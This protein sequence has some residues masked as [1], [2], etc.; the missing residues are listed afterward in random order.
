MVY[1]RLGRCTICHTR[2]SPDNIYT[3]NNCNHTY[4]KNCI[5]R[6]I[7]GG[8]LAPAAELI[9]LWMI[10]NNFLLK[11]RVIVSQESDEDELN[12]GTSNEVVPTPAPV[13]VKINV[14]V[15]DLNNSKFTLQMKTNNT[16]LNLKNKVY[17]RKGH[18][19]GEQRLIYS[20]RQLKDKYKLSHYKIGNNCIVDLV[21]RLEGG[22]MC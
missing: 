17:E 21:M 12:E 10:L 8:K 4:H 6:W 14:I 22:K 15:R 20:G 1:F 3:L 2:L 13:N 7:E 16:V 19:V 5:T 18:T 11:K 9:L